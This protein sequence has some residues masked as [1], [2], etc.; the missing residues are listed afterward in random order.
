MP[1]PFRLSATF[2]TIL[3]SRCRAWHGV[4]IAFGALCVAGAFSGC[5]TTDYGS[6]SPEVA[7]QMIEQ[8]RQQI[9]AEAP[10]DYFV[11]RRYY[12]NR[13]RAWGYLRRPGEP[14]SASKLVIFR[15]D[16]KRQP[17]RLTERGEGSGRYGYDHNHEYIIRGSFTGRKVYDPNMN[18]FLPEFLLTDYQVRDTD[19]GFLFQPGEFYNPNYPPKF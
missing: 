2:A 11:G 1:R 7:R 4:A 15:E 6:V 17:D 12:F 13:I 9:A 14:W 8:R 19:P 18:G 10:G 16:R 3:R 5:Q